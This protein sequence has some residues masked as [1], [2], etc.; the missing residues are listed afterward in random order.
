MVPYHQ[1][2]AEG[3]RCE[4]DFGV[5]FTQLDNAAVSILKGAGNKENQVDQPPDSQSPACQQEQDA[6]TDL[7]DI[8]PVKAEWSQEQQE[9]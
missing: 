5:L 7:A 1:S 2:W 3:K 8:H 4:S 6:G 9:Q